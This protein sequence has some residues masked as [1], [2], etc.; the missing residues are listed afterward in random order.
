[1]TAR[2]A[3]LGAGA[4]AVAV[5]AKAAM[6]RTWVNGELRQEHSVAD[7]VFKPSELVEYI[8][9]FATLEPGD[10]IVTGTPAGVGHGMTPPRYLSHDD[11][12][13]IA[14]DGLGEI[15]NRVKFL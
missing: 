9:T 8:S 13:Q 1:M 15:C 12:V 7:L 14:I 5:A 4:K 3:I 6:L 11:D 10:V 2:L